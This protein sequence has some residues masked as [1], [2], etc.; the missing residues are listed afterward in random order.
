MKPLE[1]IR[2]LDLSRVL[3]CPFASMILAELGAEVTKV[4]QP[5]S[6]DE[7]R[8]FEP[9]AE[10]PGGSVSGYFMSC[11]RS[12][13]SVTVNLRHAEGQ[14]IIRGLAAQA[15][16]LLENFPVGTLKRRGLDWPSLQGVNP[17]LVYLSCTGF[18]QT[19][20][21]AKRKG[22][23]TVFQAMGGLM[24]LTGERGGGPVK[25]GLPVADLT[26]GLWVAIA[27][28]TAL[29]GRDATGQGGFVDFSMLDGQVS[30]LTIA[31]ARWFALAEVPPRLG[32]EHPGRVPTASFRCRDGRFLHITCSDQHW[33]PLCRALQLDALGADAGLA[34]NAGRVARRAEVMDALTAAMATLTRAEAVA[35]LDAQDVPNGPVLALDEV[36]ADE[37]VAARGMVARVAHPVLGDFPALP[38]PLRFDGWDQPVAGRPPLLGEH[39]DEILRDRLGYD[40]ARIASLREAGAI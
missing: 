35:A 16:V 2:I 29:R 38:V 15:D 3:A 27:V 8:S 26:S 12:K 18:G 22:Y 1:G 30:L 10:G 31:A 40:A 23:D 33:A 21:Y 19:G 34:A 20:P 17:R 32:T 6:G 28:L 13:R 9:F 36:L 39:T 5:G 4:E 37:H 14:A 7:T 24:S 11:N 25:P